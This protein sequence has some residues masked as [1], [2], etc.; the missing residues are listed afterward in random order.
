LKAQESPS[1]RFLVQL[2]D[3]PQDPCPEEAVNQMA[4]SE[5]CSKNRKSLS[6]LS[7]D[8]NKQ[9]KN[10]QFWTEF[11]D[12]QITEHKFCKENMPCSKRVIK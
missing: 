2:Q 12:K 8:L 4:K 9:T 6:R 3:Q 10:A 5:T 1:I 11:M 7:N